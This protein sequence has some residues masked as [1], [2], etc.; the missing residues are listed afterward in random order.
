M[1]ARRCFCR[2]GLRSA[3]GVGRAEFGGRPQSVFTGETMRNKWSIRLLPCAG[4]ARAVTVVESVQRGLVADS[5]AKDNAAVQ[6][7]PRW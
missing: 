2:A 3:A 7:G 5:L 6:V 4:A 1:S